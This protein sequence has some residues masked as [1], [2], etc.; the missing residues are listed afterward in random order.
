MQ[1]SIAIGIVGTTTV[2]TG[3]FLAIALSTVITRPSA[4]S[5]A[6]AGARENMKSA[7]DVARPEDVQAAKPAQLAGIGASTQTSATNSPAAATNAPASANPKAP[8]ATPMW[9]WAPRSTNADATDATE[10]VVFTRRFRVPEGVKAARVVVSAD[11]KAVVKLDGKELMRTTDWQEPLEVDLGALSAG[12]H[13]LVIDAKN[14]GGPAG[15]CAVIEWNEADGTRTR[16]VT[17]PAWQA[18]GAGTSTAVPAAVLASLGDAP[19]GAEIAA[20]FGGAPG[21]LA[22]IARAIAVPP[23]FICELVYVAPR[24]R[25]SIVALATDE[26]HDRL[27]ASAQYGRMFAITPAGDGQPASSSS[28]ALIEPEIGRA[29]GVLVVDNDLF[30]VVNEGGGD[31]RGVWRLRDSNR[32]GTYD[33]KKMLVAIAKDGGEH[34]PHQIVAAPDGSLWVVGGNHCAVPEPALANSRL[35]R[36]GADQHWEEDIAFD[37]LWDANGHAVGVMAPGGWIARTDREGSKWELITAGFRNSYDLAFDD[38]GRAYTYDS[39]ME[40]DMGLPWYRPTR[41][42]ELAS[43]VDYGWRSGSGKWPEWS[44]DSLPPA[45]N[46]GPASPTGVLS[47]QGLQFPQPWNDCMFFL[48]WTFGT[49]WAGF[50]TDESRD[51]SSP[52]FRVEPFVVGRPLPLT[53]AVVM[54]GA[55]Y[56]SVGG[57]NLPSAVFRVRAENPVAIK[58][59]PLKTP[60]ALVKR[61]ELEQY[62]RPMEWAAGPAAVAAAFEGLASADAGVRSAARIAL[63]HQNPKQWRDRALSEM[64]PQSSILA[65]VA[66]CRMGDAEID[67]TPVAARLVALEPTVRGTALEREWLRACELWMLRFASRSTSVGGG[68]AVRTAVLANY[69]AKQAAADAGLAW[70]LDMHRA[71]L[72]AKLGAPEAVTIAVALLERPDTSVQQPVD[73]AL[74]ARG[75]P[76][77]KAV[78]DMLA[79]APSTQKIGIAYAI[80]NAQRGWTLDARERFARALAALKKGTGGNSFAGFLNR[81]AEEFVSHAPEGERDRLVAAIGGQ[82][83]DLSLPTPRGPGHAW[84]VAEIVALGPKLVG[85]RDHAEGLRAYRATQCAQCHRAGGI[86]GSGGPELTAVS[87]RFSLEDLAMSLVEPS[88]TI[89]DQYEN[90]DFRLKDGSLVTGRKV[91]ETTDAIEVRTSLFSDARETLAKADIASATRSALSPMPANLIDTLSE[92]ELLDLLAFLRAGGNAGDSAFVKTDDD[93]YLEIFNGTSTAG[94]SFDP[95][96]WSLEGGVLV[97]RTTEANP[98]PHNTF[99][100]WNGE[101]RDFE[102]EV[103]LKVDGNNSGVQYRSELFGEH[104]LRGPQ[105]DAH[106]HSPYVAMCYEE[107]GRGILAERGNELTIA[108]DGARSTKPLQG[109]NGASPATSEWHTY[110]VVAR[111]NRMEHFLDGV[112]TATVIDDSKERAKGGKIG[113]QIHGGEPT[114]V[115]VR[116]ARLKRLD[117]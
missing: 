28:I 18:S 98:A 111:G 65:L 11:N 31:A 29:H 107:G 52:Q 69:P 112:P 14:E 25:G 90:T 94:F 13:E 62:H 45:V 80:R 8:L 9:I 58:R 27:I 24:T 36:F 64:S 113:V 61:R 79:N 2:F 20:S 97:G 93:G 7:L 6:M 76:Y 83:L 109:S 55:M 43:G 75:G 1:K 47:S 3:L 104:R 30:A 42:C 49:M 102:L 100:V 60:A 59:S 84:T 54:N 21:E 77:G 5:Q 50:I 70:E 39:D 103:V 95:R 51:A 48:D 12:V 106:P 19:W 78:A 53:D 40:W 33:E 96:F 35:P 67:G 114:T 108:S 10:S 89:S 81:I 4:E 99:F 17:D 44:P 32:D 92:A 87:R 23:G 66:L 105:I 34:G 73:A 74:L 37:R 68:D 22:D 38:V 82:P 41:V 56:F 115:S 26:A 110:R 91:G 72:L 86:G 85:G 46:I 88:R 71:N 63:E 15:L 116:S 101:V 16:V 117:P 57:R